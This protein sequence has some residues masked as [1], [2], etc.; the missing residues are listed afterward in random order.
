MTNCYSD[1]VDSSVLAERIGDHQAIKC[2]LKFKVEQAARFEKIL[3]R[4]YSV[5]NI[6]N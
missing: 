6:N 3:I 5:N 1:F 2:E 4:N